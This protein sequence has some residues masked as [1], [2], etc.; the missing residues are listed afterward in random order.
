MNISILYDH[1]GEANVDFNEIVIYNFETQSY[2]TKFQNTLKEN[3]INT[4]SA[5]LIDFLADGSAIIEDNNNGKI[6]YI[7]DNGEVIWEFMNLNSKNKVYPV[8]WARLI[9]TE[10]SNKIRDLIK[11]KNE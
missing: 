6:Y 1:R 8:V 4:V 9:D 3:K 7:N 10:K 2:S 5:G 11:E